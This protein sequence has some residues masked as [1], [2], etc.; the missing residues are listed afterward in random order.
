YQKLTFSRR[1][2]NFLS[3]HLISQK[4]G[5]IF[6]LLD[7][8]FYISH[9]KFHKKNLEFVVRILLKNEYPLNIIF[10]TIVVPLRAQGYHSGHSLYNLRVS[11]LP[12]VL[13][14]YNVPLRAWRNHR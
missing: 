5:I 9:P 8:L 13:S 14:R 10:D 11:Q 4:K 3:P 12:V 1:F 7:K 2:L 6:N